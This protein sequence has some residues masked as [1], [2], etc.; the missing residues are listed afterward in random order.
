MNLIRT[1]LPGALSPRI[2][3]NSIATPCMNTVTRCRVRP[4]LAII[5]MGLSSL[6]NSA[7]AQAQII[8]ISYSP[9]DQWAQ[10]VTN[11]L[12][13]PVVLHLPDYRFACPQNVDDLNAQL[14]DKA[15]LVQ[16]KKWDLLLST[17]NLMDIET[18]PEFWRDVDVDVRF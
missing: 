17:R 12:G 15:I 4:V 9:V 2:A 5:G 11:L 14:K 7:P 18:P 3:A 16:G 13:K 1:L 10:C 8:H 6:C